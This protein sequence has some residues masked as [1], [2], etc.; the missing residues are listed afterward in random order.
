MI[1]KNIISHCLV[2][3]HIKRLVEGTE[4][5]AW[6]MLKFLTKENV[7]ISYDQSSKKIKIGQSEN[8]ILT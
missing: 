4:F 6:L 2:T 5:I 3:L 1:C 7:F 8:D